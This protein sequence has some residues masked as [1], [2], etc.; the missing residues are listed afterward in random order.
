MKQMAQVIQADE[1]GTLVV[2]ADLMGRVEPGAR[3]SVE[4]YGDVVILRRESI[5]ADHWWAR[6]TPEQRVS[7][8]NEW[9]SRL[10]ASAAL[11]RSATGRDSIYE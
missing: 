2:S 9:T 5:D 10:P 1:N 11:P 3:F 7:W 6:T 8:L 4:P